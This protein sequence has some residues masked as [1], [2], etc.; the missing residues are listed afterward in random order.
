[1]RQASS[2][3]GARYLRRG[4]ALAALTA[5]AVF[6]AGT[7]CVD[8]IPLWTCLDPTTGKESNVDYDPNHYVGGVLDP[9]HCF[10]PC[11]PSKACPIVV[12]GGALSPDAMCDAG[13][14][15]P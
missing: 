7:A 6:G 1:M 12:D 5:A 8:E 14:D 2:P 3:R 9:C 10:D 11:G 13:A 4:L 15:G